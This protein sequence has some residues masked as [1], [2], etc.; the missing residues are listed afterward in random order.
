MSN[1]KHLRRRPSRLVSVF[2]AA[3]IHMG[4]STSLNIIELSAHFVDVEMP[5]S[6]R[7]FE[8]ALIVALIAT[9]ALLY[10]EKTRVRS[11]LLPHYVFKHDETAGTVLVQGTWTLEADEIASPSQTTTIWCERS[12]N[13][14]SEVTAVLVGNDRF[15]HYAMLMPATANEL[16][17]I[18]WNSDLISAR[19]RT[20]ACVDT[21]I[22]IQPKT[23]AVSGSVIPRGNCA[24][25]RVDPKEMRLIDGY[26]ASMAAHG[27]TA[28]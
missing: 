15:T 7:L 11:P 20:A 18:R 17:I 9:G 8:I 6:R 26:K 2:N 21:V 4:D 27:F 5:W 13:K 22:N 3:L 10:V 19:G 16:E 1:G 12:T 14:C 28:R 24:G 23:N 25:L